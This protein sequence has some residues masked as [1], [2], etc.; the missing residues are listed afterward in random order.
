ML[1]RITE[2][3]HNVLAK[4]QKRMERTVKTLGAIDHAKY[5]S[6]LCEGRREEQRQIIDGTYVELLLEME[7]GT[8]QGIVKT[9]EGEGDEA[10]TEALVC[11]IL[12]KLQ[13]LH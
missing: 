9:I 2:H 10:V 5:R 12:Q 6:A 3:I 7:T 1:V 13:R 11:D 4:L 8:R